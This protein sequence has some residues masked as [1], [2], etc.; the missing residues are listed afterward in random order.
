VRGDLRKKIDKLE[1]EKKRI[2]TESPDEVLTELTKEA[3]AQVMDAL[4]SI[5]GRV[6]HAMQALADHGATHGGQVEVLMAGLLGQL[7]AEINELRA[8]HSLPDLST[9]A[10]TKL[11]S[12]VAQWA[13]AP[14]AH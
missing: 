12:E 9:A 8:A 10:D 4:G 2:K 6:R 5:R 3:N 7:Q 13:G 11:A 1:R 14:A